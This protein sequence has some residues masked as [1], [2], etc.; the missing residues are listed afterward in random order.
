MLFGILFNDRTCGILRTIIDNDMLYVIE[1]FLY[2]Y[3]FHASQDAISSIIYRCN[4]GK[5]YIFHRHLVCYGGLQRATT[6]H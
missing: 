4:N 5:Q 2:R 3:T 6:N 1:F